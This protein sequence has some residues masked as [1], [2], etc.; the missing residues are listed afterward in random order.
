MP[1]E[2][3]GRYNVFI[4]W[5]GILNTV[6]TL[7]I[8]AGFFAQGIVKYRE[9]R[10]AFTSSLLGLSTLLVLLW[11]VIYLIF[12][13]FFN[14][15][16]SLT[17]THMILMSVM[18][19]TSVTF[20]FW[21]ALERNDYHYRKLVI[22]TLITLIAKPIVAVWLIRRS[23]DTALAR[24]IGF[25]VVEVI[26]YFGL[27][28][29]MMKKG[30]KIISLPYWKYA[31][32]FCIPLIPHF[33][34]QTILTGADRIMI[35]RFVSFSAAGIYS[36]AYSAAMVMGMFNTALSQTLHPWIFRKIKTGEYDD[37]S[38][39]ADITFVIVAAV[40]IICIGF[41]PELVRLFAPSSY[42]DAIWV[43][44]PVALSVFFMY[45]YDIVSTF[46]LYYENTAFITIGSLIAAGTNVVLNAIF[47]PRFGYYAAGYTTLFSYAV[48]AMG[49]FWYM[50]RICRE[51]CG[52]AQP[53]NTKFLILVSVILF[54]SAGIL[55]LSYNHTIL[56]LGVMITALSLM[57]LHRRRIMEIFR[58]L[59]GLNS[60]GQH[61]SAE[62]I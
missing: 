17:E 48:Y 51:S 60:T 35:E 53:F 38:P 30:K 5:F 61:I 37:I 16:F 15:L 31:L 7:H 10:D 42:Y 44:P 49:H 47:I 25:A 6:I 8:Y 4:T 29:S 34:S 20:N 14:R 26:M 22:L 40:N 33:L 21:A 3:F 1:T 2:D 54:V 57:V 24:I 52:N 41:A 39:I 46:A 58:T 32:A 43:I 23:Q 18:M 28:I 12:R 56:R 13:T 59:R 9:Q 62:R 27:Y 11:T 55:A 19:L 45:V 50:R 36:V